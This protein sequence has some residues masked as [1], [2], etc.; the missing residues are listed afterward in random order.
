MATLIM[1]FFFEAPINGNY[2]RLLRCG[3][4]LTLLFAMLALWADFG[5][6]YGPEGVL[7]Q[8][9]FAEVQPAI[10][11]PYPEVV[12]A[13]HA[14]TAWPYS[15]LLHG[16]A[17]LY[18][19]LCLLLAF[20]GRLHRITAA[21]LLLLHSSL[22]TVQPLYSYGFDFLGSVALFYCLLLPQKPSSSWA[23]PWLRVVQLHV[24]LIYFFSGISK[25]LGHTWRNGEALYKAMGL[26]VAPPFFPLDA[27][28][29]TLGEY[30]MALAIGGW[31]VLVLEMGYAAGIWYRPTYPLFLY[32][33]ISLHVAIALLIGLYHFSAIMIVFNCA[34]FLSDPPSSRR[35]LRHGLPETAKSTSAAYHTA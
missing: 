28:L 31:T 10:G 1:R 11:I 12:Q 21:A 33:A 8:A 20:V 13:I 5:A 3:T 27:V 32:G 15:V 4:G 18:A 9:L 29:A 17:A 26:P 7:P 35:K 22:F 16:T 34:A 24:C 19:T 30:P 2:L 25:V 14:A 6:L 23:R